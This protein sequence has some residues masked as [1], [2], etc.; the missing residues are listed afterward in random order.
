MSFK[1]PEGQIA[2]WLEE[3]APFV[4]KVEY[5]PGAHHA[6][7]DAMSRRPCASTGCQYC[8]KRDARESEL[9]L[10]EQGSSHDVD[11]PV[12][13]EMQTIGPQEWRVQQEQDAD[14]QPVLQWV[15]AG[16]KPQWGAVAGCSPATKGLIA[17]FEALKLSDGVLQR[18]WKHPAT[19]EER[20]QVVVPRSLRESVL[21]ASHGTT[22]AGHF[23]VTKTLRRLRQSFYWGQARRDVEDF[24]RRCDLCTA[25][26][27]PLDQSHAQ[28]QQLAVGAPMER[29]AVDVMGPFPRTERG[30]RYVLAAMDY[31]T[32]WPE[33][34]AIPDQEAETVADVLVEG[35]FA[36]FGAA[37]YIHSDQGRNFESRVF[38]AMCDRLG[39][40]KTRTTPLHPQSDGLVERFNRTLAKQLAILTAEHQRDWDLH[41]PLVLLAYRSAVQESTSCSPALLMLGRELRT[42]AEMV[43]GRPPDTPAVP[44]GPE[45][46]RRLQ[47]WMETAHAFARDQLQKA[48]MRQKRNYDV[49]ARGK[50]FKS[51]DLVWVYSP[52]RKR[53]RCRKLDCHWV[54][55]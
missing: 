52:K 50:D 26:K 20:W 36:R 53:G 5:R 24:C 12:C 46:S 13:R 45:Y 35:M 2:R 22:G 4:F 44:P 16:Q 3:L 19:G 29:V 43:F 23:G 6:N 51:G 39:M 25:H 27:G 1:E 37:E 15:G 9:R 11:G 31:F 48:G 18:A 54:G 49:K 30:N 34:Y 40:T 8:E 42:P 33:A 10:E 21:K 47:D 41:L 14:L 55:P 17:K 28:L 38:A 32:K 7:A